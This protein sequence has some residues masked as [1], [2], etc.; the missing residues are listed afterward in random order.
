MPCLVDGFEG[1]EMS[2][3]VFESRPEGELARMPCLVKRLEAIW[4]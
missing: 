2:A 1:F 3:A 4:T